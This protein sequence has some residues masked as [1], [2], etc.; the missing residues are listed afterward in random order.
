[1]YD[2]FW[3]GVNLKLE[4]AT[5]FLREMGDDLHPPRTDSPAYAVLESTGATLGE[6]WNQNQFWAHLDAFLAMARSVDYVI[7]CCFGADRGSKTMAHWFDALPKEEQDRR[8]EF[9]KQYTIFRDS[10]AKVPLSTA[11]NV[12][13][14]R[15]G[16]A[17]V[18]VR[19]TGRFGVRYLGNPS[20][21]LRR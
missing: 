19:V 13:L 6:P 7:H 16:L 12:T 3:A 14:H 17:P 10:F 9:T 15:S 5:L 11:R 1:M 21:R 18:E 2:E 8:R 20:F 4:N